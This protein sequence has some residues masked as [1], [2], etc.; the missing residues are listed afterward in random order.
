MMTP[1]AVSIPTFEEK[2]V[3]VGQDILDGADV[4]NEAEW[5][6]KDI[7]AIYRARRRLERIIHRIKNSSKDDFRQVLGY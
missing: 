5:I 2:L 6:M 7:L 4:G 3:N 1:K